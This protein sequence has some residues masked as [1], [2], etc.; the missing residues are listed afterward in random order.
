MMAEKL[1]LEPSSDLYTGRHGTHAFHCNVKL[2]SCPLIGSRRLGCMNANHLPGA[3]RKRFWQKKWPR[4]VLFNGPPII[5]AGSA[6]VKSWRDPVFDEWM[7]G[8]ATTACAW[9]ILATMVRVATAR[10]E[11]QKDGPD[12][13]HEGL[14]KSNRSSITPVLT[15]KASVGRCRSIPA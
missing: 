10:A 13:V 2:Q 14:W 6:A 9:L 11:D 8:L 12:V 4:E 3:Q 7:F 1:S 15:V 5:V